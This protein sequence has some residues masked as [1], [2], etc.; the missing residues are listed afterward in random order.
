MIV[1][2]NFDTNPDKNTEQTN[3]EEIKN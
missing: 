3:T 2:G 1:S